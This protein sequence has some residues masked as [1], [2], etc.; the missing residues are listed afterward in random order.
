MLHSQLVLNNKVDR[1]SNLGYTRGKRGDD[2]E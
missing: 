2:F 1:D